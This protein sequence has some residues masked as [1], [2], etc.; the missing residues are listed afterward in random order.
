MR[1]NTQN[2]NIL[3][4]IIILAA[5][6]A[7]VYFILQQQ[8]PTTTSMATSTS[9]TSTYNLSTSTVP[10]YTITEVPIS[11]G[12][13]TPIAPDYT[14]PLAFSSSVTPDER[15]SLQ[16]QFVQVQAALAQNKLDFGSW[17]TLGNLRKEAGDYAGAAL[18]WQYA[19][20]EF[21]NNVVSFANLADLYTNFM[22]DYPK[23]AAAYK[24]EIKNNPSQPYIYED[25][26]QLYTTQ[27]PQGSSA[28]EAVLQQGIAANPKAV[29]L[30]LDLARYYKSKGETA[31]AQA[32]YQAAIANATAQGQTSSAAQ[33]QQE[34]GQ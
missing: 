30:Q 12:S 18:D 8:K 19:S 11:S 10:G 22:P 24:Q 6:A 28:P 9:A 4:G 2:R 16:A 3:I 34:A 14:M 25:L 1:M 15:T 7:A 33:I 21:P 20:A 32:E 29:D 13:H 17:I 26:F 5:L 27:Y 31:Q 23:A